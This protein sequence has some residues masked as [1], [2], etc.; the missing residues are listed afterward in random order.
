MGGLGICDFVLSLWNLWGD[1][2]TMG[3]SGLPFINIYIHTHICVHTHTYIYTHCDSG[4]VLDS[5]GEKLNRFSNLMK[6]WRRN[7]MAM[8]LSST[9]PGIFSKFPDLKFHIYA[10]YISYVLWVFHIEGIIV[11]CRSYI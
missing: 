4:S 2:K 5:N 8:L 10:L 11:L 1:F 3:E 6:G 7:E 9:S